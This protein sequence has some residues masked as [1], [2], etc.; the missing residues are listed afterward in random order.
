MSCLDLQ[1]LIWNIAGK[2]HSTSW[3]WKEKSLI[4]QFSK[5]QCPGCKSTV[6]PC[7]QKELTLAEN[8]KAFCSAVNLSLTSTLP[9][10]LFFSCA[11]TAARGKC[12][13][14]T[15]DNITPLTNLQTDGFLPETVFTEQAVNLERQACSLTEGNVIQELMILL[16]KRLKGPAVVKNKPST[17][18]LMECG[19]F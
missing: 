4:Y 13:N 2:Y 6:I 10:L 12:W 14:W 7:Y 19:S 15:A 8:Q 9:L 1:T 18:F 11:D 16:D 5:A 17:S 3:Q